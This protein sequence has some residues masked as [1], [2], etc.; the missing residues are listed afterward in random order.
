[1]QDLKFFALNSDEALAILKALGKRAAEDMEDDK[2]A[3]ATLSALA[4]LTLARQGGEHAPMASQIL[5]DVVFANRKQPEVV[6]SQSL[7]IAKLLPMRTNGHVVFT[8][9]PDQSMLV[10][11]LERGFGHPGN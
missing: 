1:M 5:R 10:W 2:E 3:L 8:V 4:K 9:F 11:D 6:A 7:A